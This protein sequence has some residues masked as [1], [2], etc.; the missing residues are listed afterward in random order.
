M[1]PTVCHFGPCSGFTWSV[2][3]PLPGVTAQHRQEIEAVQDDLWEYYRQLRDYQDQPSQTQKQQLRVR[4]DEILV[5][6]TRVTLVSIWRCSSSAPIKQSCSRPR[7]TQ[8]LHTNAAEA[9]IREYVT[10]RKIS[11]TMMMDAVPAIRLW[12]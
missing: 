12:A 8:V 2:A 4:F 9:D 5:S 10:R 3:S 11:G 6:V 7:S 1:E